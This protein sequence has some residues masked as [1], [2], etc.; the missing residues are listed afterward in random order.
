MHPSKKGFT[1][2]EL[3]VVITILVILWTIAFISL[4][5]YA[6]DARDSVR[7]QDI[8]NIKKSLELF[9]TEKWFYS[10]PSDATD[11]TYSWA[12]VWQQWTVW[13]SVVENL[14]QLNKKPVDP[15]L[16]TEYSYSR[17]NAKTEYELTWILEW[18][19][20]AQTRVLNQTNA[21]TNFMAIVWWN[22]N[23]KVLKVSTWWLD[24]LLAL[25]SI[26]TT[27]V[28]TTDIVTNVTNKS[29][30]YN[31]E[32]NLA[33]NF[34]AIEWFTT[35]GWFE[36]SPSNVVVFEW[37]KAD[38][39]ISAGKVEFIENLQNAYSGSL[40]SF[41][42]EFENLL[43][44]DAQTERSSA[45]SL[46]LNIF[47]TVPQFS[48]DLEIP[49][50]EPTDVTDLKLWL[51]GDDLYSITKDGSNLVSQWNDKSGNDNHATQ[52]SSSNQLTFVPNGLNGK[53][54][55]SG[56]G[57]DYMLLSSGLYSFPNGDST[58]FAVV[59]KDADTIP[60]KRI[61]TAAI[62]GSTKVLL[63]SGAN[64]FAY[65]NNLSFA[66]VS[67]SE[68]PLVWSIIKAKR[69]DSNQFLWVV[70][71][72]EAI[73]TSWVDVTGINEMSLFSHPGGSDAWDGDI[74]EFLI[75]GKPLNVTEMSKVETYLKDKWDL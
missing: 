59:I 20:V 31:K 48:K 19:G 10:N 43:S 18:W 46:A 9:V 30:V 62:S 38:L 15:I 68:N 56:D 41:K 29:L 63:Y 49:S 33:S 27:D 51:D 39:W 28:S 53:S 3:I 44:F 45:T 71:G 35:T 25:P 4:Q 37:T 52:G 65:Y 69:Q 11:I 5:W 23:G 67:I 12:I 60:F 34:N 73:D 54:V 1:L 64:A 16:G 7:A 58:I 24:Y 6:K 57:A 66:W 13:D 14:W 42:W 17:T 47:E 55:L 36:Y 22:Y 21:A 8:A 50:F 40:L 70:H 74:A 72:S 32:A 26:T 61:F 2:V 75:Y